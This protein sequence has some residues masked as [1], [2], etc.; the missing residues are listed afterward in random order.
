MRK[1][2]RSAA[3]LLAATTLLVIVGGAGEALAQGCICARQTQPVFGGQ[4]D[5]YLKRGEWQLG[6][7]YRYQHSNTLYVGSDEAVGVPKVNR[8]QHIV[9]LSGT[10]AL[11][12]QTNVTLTVPFA[13]L[14]FGLGVPPPSDPDRT[15]T[16][17]IGDVTLVARHWLMNC[18]HHPGGNLSLGLGVKFPTGNYDAEDAFRDGAGVR[19]VRPVDISTQPGDGGTGLILDLQGFRRFKNFTIFAGGTYLSNPRD[20]NGTA[21]LPFAIMGAGVPRNVRVNSV[22]DQYVARVGVAT[23][24]KRSKGLSIS[25]AARIEGVPADD[26]F[27]DSNGFRFAGYGLFIEPGIAYTRGQSTWALSA[28]VRVH[29]N[30]TSLSHTPG[31]NPGTVVPHAILFSYSR[32]FGK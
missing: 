10:Y 21:S 32:R 18:D 13:D 31:P 5:P 22:P 16:S 23:P 6:F 2:S 9:D 14:R 19:R 8:T 17:G 7:A 26:L 20:T 12:R 30:I 24:A 29:Q 25:L 11:S 3:Q 15:H 27:G 1:T 28:P 4:G